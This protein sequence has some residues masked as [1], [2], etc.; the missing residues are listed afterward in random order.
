MDVWWVRATPSSEDKLWTVKRLVHI[1]KR[2]Y[3]FLSDSSSHVKSMLHILLVKLQKMLLHFDQT[4][5]GAV[6]V[7][8]LKTKIPS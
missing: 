8:T 3:R 6:V 7:V 1:S 4:P 2:L 5:E